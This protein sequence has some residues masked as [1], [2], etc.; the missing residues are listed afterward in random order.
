MK[1]NR[2]FIFRSPTTYEKNK[3]E[4]KRLDSEIQN[5][6]KQRNYA[7]AKKLQ[8]DYDYCLRVDNYFQQQRCQ[9][10]KQEEQ[11]RLDQAKSRDEDILREELKEEMNL[12]L[13][14][15]EDRLQI[16]EEEHQKNLDDLYNRYSRPRYAA[17]RMSP[18]LQSLLKAESYYANRRE[19]H[20]AEQYKN[21][22]TQQAYQEIVQ[23]EQ[24]AEQSFAAA[25]EAENHR[26]EIVKKGFHSHLENEKLKLTNKTQRGLLTIKNKYSRLALKHVEFNKKV[27][28]ENPENDQELNDNYEESINEINEEDQQNSR[29]KKSFKFVTTPNNTIKKPGTIYDELENGFSPILGR[30]VV[31]N[32]NNML[33]FN[34]TTQPMQQPPRS[35]YSR[36]PRTAR[37]R[38]RAANFSSTI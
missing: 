1:A 21:Q 9:K 32:R 2:T 22:I 14:S 30:T 19:F 33:L 38:R 36:S 11:Q 35:L 6:T 10:Q 15:Y 25:V 31:P 5:A 18:N 4:L 8:A 12:K 28:S 16:I 24:N 3:N 7:Q 17:Y 26:Y 29:G 13:N 34:S 27:N 37:T 23:T 20:M